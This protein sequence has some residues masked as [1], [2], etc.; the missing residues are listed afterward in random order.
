[1]IIGT[2]TSIWRYPTKSLRAES[3]DAV[4]VEASG[5]RG[6]RE[7]AFF[8]RSYGHARSGKTYRGKENDRLHLL[9]DPG[10][11]PE[12]AAQNAVDVE[13]RDGERFFD[14]AF[15]PTSS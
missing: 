5:L 6:D 13:F 3:L 14:D 11:V 12:L 15:G 10:R 9:D 7:R 1:M 4:E 8:V 2:L